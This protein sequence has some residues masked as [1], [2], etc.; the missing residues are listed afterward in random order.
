MEIGW[1]NFAHESVILGAG[2]GHGSSL[3]LWFT[4]KGGNRFNKSRLG[5][6]E[7]F[8]ADPRQPSSVGLRSACADCFLHLY[9]LPMPP[10]V[11]PMSRAPMFPIWLIPARGRLDMSTILIIVRRCLQTPSYPNCEH[12]S[13]CAP[14]VL[15]HPGVLTSTG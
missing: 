14:C 11:I 9:Q 1:A 6:H 8:L 12:R 10:S 3:I 7:C 4:L 15:S 13:P 5:K 2:N